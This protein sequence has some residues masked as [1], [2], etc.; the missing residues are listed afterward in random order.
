MP[1]KSFLEN[2]ILE[3]FYDKKDIALKG[4]ESYK[5]YKAPAHQSEAERF[6]WESNE[7]LT[8]L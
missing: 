2:S 4:R 6:H 5:E 1:M 8:G 7:F 3:E